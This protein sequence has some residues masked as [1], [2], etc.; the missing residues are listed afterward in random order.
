MWF[1]RDLRLDDNPALNAAIESG[2]PVIPVFLCDEEIERLGA[3]PKWRLGLGIAAFEER[4]SQVKSRL[5]LRRGPALDCLKA[6]IVETGARSVFW[7][8]LYDPGS[9]ARDK[10]VKSGLCE[11]GIEAES[12]P[13]HLLFEP[14]NVAPKAGGF[15]KVYTPFWRAAKDLEPGDALDPPTSIPTPGKWPQSDDIDDWDLGRAMN[16]GASVVRDFVCVGEDRAARRLADFIA[17]KIAEYRSSRDLPAVEGTSRLSENLTYGEISPRRAWNAGWRALQEGA[18][19]AETFLRELVWREFAYHLLFH[20]PRIATDNWREDW[21][22]FPWSEDEEEA[23]VQAWKTGRTGYAFV[24]AAMRQLY[25]TG[26]MHNRAR[27]IAA[28]FLT[29]HLMCHWKIGQ[30]WFE[31][32]LIDW[33]PAANAMGWQWAAGSGPDAAPFFRIF[34][35]ETQREKFD[36]K[37]KYAS[38]WIA[39]GQSEPPATALAFFD[40]VPRQWALS[41]EAPVP[42]P[43]VGL[44]EG[45]ARALAAYKNRKS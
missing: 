40:A 12:H 17:E 20:T 43:V 42:S 1:R 26:Y 34:N 30:K 27:M 45:R 35:P 22:S 25:T 32:C 23:E 33:D 18:P 11:I 6:L 37:G 31:D 29:K 28:S 15:F 3:A 44:A 24:D 9:I 5:I 10:A 13:G 16:R 4:L 14:W 2:R 19:G 7:N 41:P 38:A 21:D 36:P 39:E 8:R